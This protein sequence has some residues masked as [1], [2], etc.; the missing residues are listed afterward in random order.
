MAD[1]FEQLI[2]ESRTVQDL[3]QRLDRPLEIPV[4]LPSVATRLDKEFFPTMPGRLFTQLASLPGKAL[5]VYMVLRRRS[6]LD[7]CA[8]VQLTSRAL[9][10]F[11]IDRQQKDAALASL[12]AHGLIT[13][14]RQN[15]KNPQVTLR[16]E[17]VPWVK[18]KK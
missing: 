17:D 10:R 16:P 3:F 9:A 5:A 2:A 7:G 4:E 13:V 11:G 18:K 8:T 15:G 14:A 1:F 6:R 12:E